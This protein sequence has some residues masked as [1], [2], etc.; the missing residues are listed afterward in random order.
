[1]RVSFFVQEQ[2]KIGALS[3]SAQAENTFTRPTS[4]LKTNLRNL[5]KFYSLH[6]TADLVSMR[7]SL[8]TFAQEFISG[9]ASTSG[10]TREYKRVGGEKYKNVPTH[11]SG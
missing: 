8:R 1:M 11:H 5:S 3:N 4:L 6:C 7:F 2:R 10:S 9:A